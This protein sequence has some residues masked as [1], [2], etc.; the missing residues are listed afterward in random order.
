MIATA[1]FMGN[2]CEACRQTGGSVIHVLKPHY[3]NCSPIN[4]GRGMRSETTKRG[5]IV[6]EYLVQTNMKREEWAR[7]YENINI[8]IYHFLLISRPYQ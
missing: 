4:R 6:I 3:Y 1:K 5:R 7:I 2:G 8:K